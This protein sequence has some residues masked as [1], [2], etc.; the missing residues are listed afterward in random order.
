MFEMRHRR[1]DA[2]R[3]AIRAQA[4]AAAFEAQALGDLVALILSHPARRDVELSAVASQRNLQ[5]VAALGQLDRLPTSDAV[6]NAADGLGASL[7]V[8]DGRLQ[9]RPT[10]DARG[11]ARSEIGDAVED[12]VF[13]ARFL[14]LVAIEE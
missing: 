10:P 12:M 7:R 4:E 8:L 14:A 6:R 1:R 5:I 11:D 13:A 3:R 9:R 2:E